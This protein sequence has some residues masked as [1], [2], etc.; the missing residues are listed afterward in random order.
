MRFVVSSRNMKFINVLLIAASMAFSMAQAQFEGGISSNGGD[1]I[2]SEFFDIA[3]KIQTAMV[4]QNY[5]KVDA[6]LLAKT[7]STAKIYSEEHVF[8]GENEVS[9]INTPALQEIRV[10]RTR[11]KASADMPK[12]KFVLVLHEFLGLMGVEDRT[13][14]I[15][16]Q[17]FQELKI[18]LPKPAPVSFD[19]P[20]PHSEIAR[21]SLA[22]TEVE[23]EEPT[24]MPWPVEA[25]LCKTPDAIDQVDFFVKMAEETPIRISFRKDK[26]RYIVVG[27]SS[28]IILQIDYT[29]KQILYTEP[30]VKIPM[31]S[32]FSCMIW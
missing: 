15:S 7:I 19:C 8:L 1:G 6:K 13:F 30:V 14:N 21:C 29:K 11:W 12:T 2:V 16:N 3:R 23:G 22:M 32:V 17:V 28:D 25:V 9:A 10:S 26:S 4:E 27:E 5:Q 18:E 20:T 31:T 24:F